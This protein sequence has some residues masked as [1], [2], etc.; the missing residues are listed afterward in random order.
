MQL[1]QCI[2]YNNKTVNQIFYHPGKYML[3]M[4]FKKNGSS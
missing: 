3:F 1:T 4:D 2:E